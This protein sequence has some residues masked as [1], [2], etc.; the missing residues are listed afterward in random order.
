MLPLKEKGIDNVQDIL[1]S[2]LPFDMVLYYNE[3]DLAIANSDDPKMK[4]IWE[5][6]QVT[7]YNAE[8][9]DRVRQAFKLYNLKIKSSCFLK[10]TSR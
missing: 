2:G 9:I 1:D 3:F 6:K 7:T 5:K 4:Q 10:S 8:E